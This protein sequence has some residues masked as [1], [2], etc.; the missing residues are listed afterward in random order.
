MPEASN[1]SVKIIKFCI[2]GSISEFNKRDV[3]AAGYALGQNNSDPVKN[4]ALVRTLW[5]IIA[6]KTLF[7]GAFYQITDF[8]IKLVSFYCHGF[9]SLGNI[10]SLSHNF[11]FDQA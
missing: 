3:A 10:L 5:Q 1:D 9:A 7:T 8:K 2:I 6:T 11:F 4:V